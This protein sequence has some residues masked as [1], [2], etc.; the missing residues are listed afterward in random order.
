MVI[1]NSLDELPAGV[2]S[3]LS[4]LDDSLAVQQQPE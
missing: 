2:F 4:S 3:G 1:G